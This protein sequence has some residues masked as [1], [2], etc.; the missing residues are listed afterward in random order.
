MNPTIKVVL[1]GAARA[2]KTCIASRLKFDRFD[3]EQASTIGAELYEF[4]QKLAKQTVDVLLWDTDSE[5]GETVLEQEFAKGADA[6]LV[7]ADA[8]DTDSIIAAVAM[9]ERFLE[10]TPSAS[11]VVA[12]NKAD[13]QAAQKNKTI[14]GLGE[15]PWVLPCSAKTGSGIK[16]LIQRAVDLR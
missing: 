12:L 1:L 6:A 8:T 7:V 10:K 3:A 15:Q 14:A 16:R 11:A 2:G 9:R 13:Q 5:L 4:E